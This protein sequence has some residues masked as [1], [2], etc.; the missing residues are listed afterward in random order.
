[1]N[2]YIYT[3]AIFVD[4]N[5]VVAFWWRIANWTTG[6]TG[7]VW[8]LG[9]SP[10]RVRLCRQGK[11]FLGRPRHWGTA[12]P[13]P[14][15]RLASHTA[16]EHGR[17]DKPCEALCLNSCFSLLFVFW[18]PK[19]VPMVFSK[20][21]L[22]VWSNHKEFLCKIFWYI[23][24]Y[25]CMLVC[26]MCWCFYYFNETDCLNFYYDHVR[27]LILFPESFKFR[28]AVTCVSARL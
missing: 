27:I 24:K 28:Y 9:V 19:L 8:S 7:T 20:I 25:I 16:W 15:Y 21:K 14:V 26:I 11:H 10:S 4:V 17:V 2:I 18:L 3:Y 12:V 13:Q 6:S 1:M 23:G 5:H 22:K